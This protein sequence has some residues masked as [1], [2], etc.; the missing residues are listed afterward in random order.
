MTTRKETRKTLAQKIY[1]IKKQN[2]EINTISMSKWVNGILKSNIVAN[3]LSD[4]VAWYERE[5][6][7]YEIA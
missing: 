1:L 3:K 5:L 4:M 2:G 6:K 7:K